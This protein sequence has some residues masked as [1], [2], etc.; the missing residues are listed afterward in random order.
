MRKSFLLVKLAASLQ[1]Y[2][3]FHEIDSLESTTRYYFF[4]NRHY[5]NAYPYIESTRNI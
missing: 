1:G 3:C 5:T 2:S 4:N